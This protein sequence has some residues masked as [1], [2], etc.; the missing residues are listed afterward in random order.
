MEPPVKSQ[1]TELQ[2][3]SIAAK[4]KDLIQDLLK[5]KSGPAADLGAFYLAAMIQELT[6]IQ[7]AKM[8]AMTKQLHE[9]KQLIEAKHP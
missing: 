4:H 3:N 7:T 1:L 5:P 8:D 6:V 2:V 9:L